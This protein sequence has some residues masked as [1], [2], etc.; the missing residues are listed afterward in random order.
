MGENSVR[1]RY[2]TIEIQNEDIHLRT[3]KDTQQFYDKNNKAENLGIS[4]ASW[5]IFGVIWPSSEV[6][7]N[8]LYDYD[9]KDKRI[10]EVGCGIGL[11]SLAL[12]KLDADI[13]ATDYHPEAGNFLDVNTKLNEDEKIPFVRASWDDNYNEELGKFDLIVGSDLLYERDHVPLLS[14]FI[15]EHAAPNC[16]AILANPSRGHQGRFNKQMEELG[17]SYEVFDPKDFEFTD[18]DYKGKLFIFEKKS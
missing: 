15:N 14:N 12:N 1:Y 9:L 8:Y 7:A 6:L 4:S 17:F 5:P 2:Q 18:K 11:V 3:L 16:K 10:L 13:T